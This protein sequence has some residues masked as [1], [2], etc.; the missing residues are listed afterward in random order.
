MVY[1]NR[2]EGLSQLNDQ[3][4]PVFHARQMWCPDIPQKV[5]RC[6]LSDEQDALIKFLEHIHQL[7]SCLSVALKGFVVTGLL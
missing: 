1:M 6:G 4:G 5:R 2:N 3:C 7:L